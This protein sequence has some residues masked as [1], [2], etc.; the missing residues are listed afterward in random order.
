MSAQLV[1]LQTAKDHLQIPSMPPGDPD[2]ADV[3][4]KLDQAEAIILDY[5]AERAD[6]A[7]VDPATAPPNVTAAILLMCARLYR[8]RGDL[9][10]A[11]ADLWL[12]IERLLKRF[13]DPG[14]A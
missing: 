2:E 13:R 9:E 7:W 10:E 12:A 4:L 5:L 11:D 3:Q 6:P 14:F 8:H 1:T